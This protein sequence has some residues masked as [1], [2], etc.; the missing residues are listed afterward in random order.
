MKVLFRTDASVALGSGHVMRC[1][2]LADALRKLGAN[3]D[4]ACRL[5]SGH[6]A[7]VIRRQGFNIL[8]LPDV[9][10][11]EMADAS[12]TLAQ[13]TQ[14][15]DLL[16]ID[17]Y[18]LAADYSRQL[19][20]HFRHIMQIDDLA[21][22]SYD[23]D[24]LLDQNLVANAEQRY[25]K[26]VPVHCKVLTG[27]RYALLREEFYHPPE[28]RVSDRILIG[29]GGSDEQNLTSL[30]IDAVNKLKIPGL[31]ADIVIGA[32][33]P[34]HAE[35]YKLTASLP[36]MRLHVQCNYMAKLMHQARLMLGGG[37]A[38]HWERCISA[39]PGLVVTVAENQQATTAFLDQLGAC[40]WLGQ[41]ADMSAEF[42]AERLCYYLSRPA[43]LDSMGRTAAGLIPA[44][45]GTPLVTETIMKTLSNGHQ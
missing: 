19:R 34:W 41:A 1:L 40:V 30:A 29:F 21:N 27:P 10:A 43:L 37:G 23:C 14:N 24:L 5:T 45:A 22:R 36:N 15:Y 42:F 3:C 25:G 7:D 32:N 4:F 20:S 12:A 39:L 26:L 28:Q 13:L 33:N 31:T 9:I 17:H 18:A 16:I 35:I 2:T 6:L 44:A 11:T 38:S 8:P